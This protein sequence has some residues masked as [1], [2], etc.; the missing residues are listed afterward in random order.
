MDLV[1]DGDLP[2]KKGDII[3]VTKRTQSNNVSPK[4]NWCWIILTT[5]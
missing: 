1:E 3:T 4:S 5:M 2:F